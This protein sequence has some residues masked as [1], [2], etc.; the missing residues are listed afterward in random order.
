LK[1]VWDKDLPALN[2]FVKQGDVPAIEFELK[3]DDGPAR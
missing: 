2:A 3:D 1:E